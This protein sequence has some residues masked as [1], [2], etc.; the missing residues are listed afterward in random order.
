MKI[1]DLFKFGGSSNFGKATPIIS[2]VGI[3]I[4]I[5]LWWLEARFEIIPTKI[6]PG[7]LDVVGSLGGLI[8][9]N[10]LFA[11]IWFSV[12]MNLSAYVWAILISLPLGIV[13]TVY[14]FLNLAVGKYISAIRFLPLPACVAIFIAISGLTYTTKLSFLVVALIIY[15][16][17][18][19]ANRVANLQNPNNDKDFV[20]LQT[21]KTMGATSFQTFRYVYWPYIT[22][23]VSG[24][25]RSLLALSWSYV[26]ISELIYKDGTINGIGALINTSIR[27]SNMSAAWVCLFIVIIIGV[28]QDIIFKFGEEILFPYMYNRK[29][30]FEK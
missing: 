11:N 6:L 17:P 28:L 24:S 8:N 3:L 16:V 21:M 12:K 20:Y 2:A 25:I 29:R 13:L 23:G 1:K 26:T 15:I 19:V 10:H 30:L 7:P 27:Q 18:E 9:E 22:S 4:I 5:C 14:P